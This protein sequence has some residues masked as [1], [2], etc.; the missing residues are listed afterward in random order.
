MQTLY[1]VSKGATTC[2][3][4]QSDAHPPL[5][6]PHGQSHRADGS[7]QS[8]LQQH[9]TTPWCCCCVVLGVTRVLGNPLEEL[10]HPWQCMAVASDLQHRL[11]QRRSVQNEATPNGGR[12]C[13]CEHVGTVMQHV[14]GDVGSPCLNLQAHQ[15]AETLHNNKET[16]RTLHVLQTSNLKCRY[17]GCT[18]LYRSSHTTP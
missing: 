15:T 12:Q 6:Q 9:T 7:N 4:N 3:T 13:G 16:A 5:S 10:S 17:A 1:L 11:W 14:E 2:L 8:H 18:P